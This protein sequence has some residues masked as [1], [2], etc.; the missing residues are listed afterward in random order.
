MD[1]EFQIDRSYKTH[2]KIKVMPTLKKNCDVGN[3]SNS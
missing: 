2:L 3:L 1:S